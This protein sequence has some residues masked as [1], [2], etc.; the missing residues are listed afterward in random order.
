MKHRP[1]RTAVALVG[2]VSLGSLTG[3]ASTSG[4]DS[5]RSEIRQANETAQQAAADAAAAR[6]EAAA[7][8]ATANEAKSTADAAKASAD[9]TAEKIDRMFKKS[10]YK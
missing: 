2:L 3:C 8:S 7:A 4:M 1:L 5:L 6:K 10:M 9:A